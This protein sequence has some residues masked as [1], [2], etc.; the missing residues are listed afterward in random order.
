MT[1]VMIVWEITSPAGM[2]SEPGCGGHGDK[3]QADEGEH[4]RQQAAPLNNLAIL[5]PGARDVVATI[6]M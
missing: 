5:L 2:P 4:N 1:I 6:A 3:V